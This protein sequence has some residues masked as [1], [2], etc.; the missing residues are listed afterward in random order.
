MMPTLLLVF[1]IGAHQLE[2]EFSVLAAPVDG[3]PAVGFDQCLGV[4]CCQSDYLLS[5]WM[6]VMLK[7][8]LLMNT[9]FGEMVSVLVRMPSANRTTFGMTNMLSSK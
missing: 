7:A 6:S 3:G 8:V 1:W 5:C 2:A 9:Y 4:A